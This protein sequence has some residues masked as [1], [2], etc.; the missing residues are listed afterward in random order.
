MSLTPNAFGAALGSATPFMA[1]NA[2][3]TP[4]GTHL[5][6]GGR[7]AAYVRSTGRQDLDDNLISD[8]L[9]QTI[10]AGLARCRSGQNDVVYVLPGHTETFSSSGSVF[11]NLVDGAQII[12]CGVPGAANCPTITLSNAGASLALNKNGVTVQGLNIKSTTA[13]LTGAVVVTG[14]WVTIAGCFISLTGALGANS[15]IQLT[16]AIGATLLGNHIVVNSTQQI[17]DVTGATSTNVQIVGNLIRQTQSSSGGIGINIASTAGISG[18]VAHNYV[19]SATNT[20]AGG[21]AGM[22]VVGASANATLGV[23]QNFSADA[24]AA[25]NSG[26][27]SPTVIT[28]T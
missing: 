27:L 17:V 25:G 1:L 14:T 28:D 22:I 18:F 13:A 16:G 15:A 6:P 23:F 5:L 4:F 9:V 12:G 20:G 10:D 24:A 8:N 7:V 26:I 3:G 19:K 21:A 2:V 11:A